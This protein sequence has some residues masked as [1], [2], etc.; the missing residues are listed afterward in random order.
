[1][2]EQE[3]FYQTTGLKNLFEVEWEEQKVVRKGKKEGKYRKLCVFI[4]VGVFDLLTVEQSGGPGSRLII[5]NGHD[6]MG[7]SPIFLILWQAFAG[8]AMNKIS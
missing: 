8:G 5:P 4:S 2:K 1:M 6:A 7:D 3:Y